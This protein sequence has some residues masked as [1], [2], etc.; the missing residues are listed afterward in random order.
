[1][2]STGFG[3]VDNSEMEG[4]LF[5][6]GS[7]GGIYPL[8]TLGW[9][10]VLVSQEGPTYFSS[11]LEWKIPL[12]A[13]LAP[14]L[15]GST[16]SCLLQT[17]FVLPNL[18]VAGFIEDSLPHFLKISRFFSKSADPLKTSLMRALKNISNDFFREL[19]WH[20]SH[21]VVSQLLED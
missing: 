18:R 10:E 6:R 12:E 2:L 14:G 3:I 11:S 16:V 20:V 8:G 1:M 17:H 4:S 15:P 9:S 13:G 19:D 21:V 5:I 7:S